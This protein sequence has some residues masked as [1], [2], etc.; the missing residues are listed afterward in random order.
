MVDI[1]ETDPVPGTPAPAGCPWMLLYVERWLRAPM[2]RE[3]GEIEP[4]DAGTP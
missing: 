4:R 2:P 1:R 3:D